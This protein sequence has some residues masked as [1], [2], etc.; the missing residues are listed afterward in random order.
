MVPVLEVE[1]S[2]ASE[3]GGEGDERQAG[4][5][6]L[7]GEIDLGCTGGMMHDVVVRQTEKYISANFGSFS[8]LLLKLLLSNIN[9][10]Y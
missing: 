1:S 4:S 2:A 5:V 10:L 6:S 8:F 3:S 7:V 9:S